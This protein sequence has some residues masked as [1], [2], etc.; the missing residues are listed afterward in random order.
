MRQHAKTIVKLMAAYV[1]LSGVA[2]ASNTANVTTP[3]TTALATA[4]AGAIAVPLA[5]G[6]EATMTQGLVVSSTLRL[7]VVDGT[8][9]EPL[10]DL[11]TNNE[12]FGIMSEAGGVYTFDLKTLTDAGVEQTAN[13]ADATMDLGAPYLFDFVTYP[14]DSAIRFSS[15]QVGQDATAAGGKLMVENLAVTATDTLADLSVTPFDGTKINLNIDGHVE[16]ISQGAYTIAGATITWLPAVA[17]YAL[18]TTDKVTVS[19]YV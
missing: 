18:E 12:V 2:V 16:P 13:V 6:N 15:Y 1:Y 3:L 17:G 9:K 19:F 4:G 7:P 11:T 8:T 10:I 14:A 5:V